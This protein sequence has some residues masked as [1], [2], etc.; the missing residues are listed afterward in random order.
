[1]VG[2]YKITNPKGKVYIGQSIDIERRFKEYKGV[3]CK[4]QRKLYY[5][6]K[7]YGWENH[8]FEVI[9]ECNEKNLIQRENYWKDFYNTLE[10]GL[11]C[12]K[13]GKFGE[14]SKETRALI[15]KGLK[16]KTKS[17]KTKEKISLNHPMRKKIYQYTLEGKLVKIWSS[18]TEAERNN[19]GNIKNNILGK[20]KHANGFLWIR[21]ED[22]NLLKDKIEKN[23]TYINPLKGKKLSLSHK[24]K[25]SENIKGKKP[26]TKTKYLKENINKIISDY[27]TLS[28]PNLA[29]KY[30]VSHPTMRNFLKKEGLYKFRKNFKGKIINF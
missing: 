11:N 28:I 23:K 12:R 30:K 8:K 4:N 5:S 17:K 24:E 10:E 14:L 26:K 2:I 25:L 13:D 9:E 20:T 22:L 16:G 6:L 27:N 3:Y 21:E 18:Y 29:V 19:K 7:K 1:M 15:S